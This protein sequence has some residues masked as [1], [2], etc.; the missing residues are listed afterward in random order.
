MCVHGAFHP[1]SLL[2]MEGYLSAVLL[3]SAALTL[4]RASTQRSELQ[5]T[6]I[7]RLS[8]LTLWALLSCSI[9]TLALALAL[10]ERLSVL[11]GLGVLSCTLGTLGLSLKRSAS[12]ACVLTSG[13]LGLCAVA[14][15]ATL[16][17]L[18]LNTTSSAAV[19]YRSHLE[20]V[21]WGDILLGLTGIVISIALGKR[22]QAQSGS[23]PTTRQRPLR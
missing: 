17:W 3:G 12:G 7:Q 10:D 1:A 21:L 16:L 9:C 19:P 8:V 20:I 22:W 15:A 2:V 4:P 6:L 13:L 18:H 11:W 5:R 14:D 23:V